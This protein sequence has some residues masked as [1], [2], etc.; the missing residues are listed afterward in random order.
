MDVFKTI[1]AEMQRLDGAVN[2]AVQEREQFIRSVSKQLGTR[3]GKKRTM[4][5]AGRK[6]ISQA[7]KARWARVKKAGA[8]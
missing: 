5:A 7:A 8:R 6:R 2:K 1:E 3:S 4:S